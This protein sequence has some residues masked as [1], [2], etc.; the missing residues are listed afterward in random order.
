MRS[1]EF[2]LT[3]DEPYRADQVQ[4]FCNAAGTC[5]GSIYS[6]AF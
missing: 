2:G 5:A 6:P 4:A 1:G 3:P